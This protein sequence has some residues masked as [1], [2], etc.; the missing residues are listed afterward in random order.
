MV[1]VKGNVVANNDEVLRAMVLHDMAIGYGY[2]SLFKE[3]LKSG[4]VVSILDKDL[5]GVAADIYAVFPQSYYMPY[6]LKAFLDV[7]AS[8][9]MV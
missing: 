1:P 2:P 3:E 7:V 9:T 4:R 8:A 6:K 5:T